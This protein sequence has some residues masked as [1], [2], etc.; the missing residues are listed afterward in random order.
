MPTKSSKRSTKSKKRAKKIV[1]F[2]LQNIK[3][4]EFQGLLKKLG[5]CEEARTWATGKSLKRAFN[6]CPDFQ[7]LPWI[8][9]R[10]TGRIPN[11]SD[12]RNTPTRK[13]SRA[14]GGKRLARKAEAAGY[15]YKYKEV[16]GPKGTYSS[17]ADVFRKY[18]TV[19]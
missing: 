17:R 6:S 3:P 5:A 13:E 12:P 19:V 15:K 8:L 11:F 7:W 2:E 14:W 9:N 1:P 10:V 18:Y 4:V 16:Y